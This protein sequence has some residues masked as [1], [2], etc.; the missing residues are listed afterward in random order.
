MKRWRRTRRNR[1]AQMNTQNIISELWAKTARDGNEYGVL[2]GDNTLMHLEGNKEEIN[3]KAWNK[4]IWHLYDNPSLMFDFYHTHGEWDSPLSGDDIA[5]FLYIAN[6]HSFAAI[7]Q[8]RIYII[9]R[10]QK[11]PTIEYKKREVVI[12]KYEQ[13][14]KEAT[15]SDKLNDKYFFY[16]D[17]FRRALCDATKRLAHEYFFDYKETKL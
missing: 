17:S 11:T 4:A 9:T 10:T 15:P 13:Y 3:D 14:T 1:I 2:I 6:V 5:T 7:T 16:I 12:A 8:E